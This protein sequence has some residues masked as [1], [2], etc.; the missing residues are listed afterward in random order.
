[1]SLLTRL[2]GFGNDLE[3][4]FSVDE[5]YASIR[6][7]HN[8][9][10]SQGDIRQ[11][12]LIDGDPSAMQEFNVILA[13]YNSAVDKEKFMADLHGILILAERNKQGLTT[14]QKVREWIND[15][16]D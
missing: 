12:F 11:E 8:G 15:L 6:A 3:L 14:P 4:K 1:M 5:F 10:I 16:V 9:K 2:G 7:Y 13:A